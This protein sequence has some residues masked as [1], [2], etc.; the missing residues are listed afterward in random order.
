MY[1]LRRYYVGQVFRARRK[2][3]GAAILGS[4]E[5]Y[6]F[7]GGVLQL[8]YV[9]SLVVSYVIF[10]NLQIFASCV[11]AVLLLTST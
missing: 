11:S 2:A 4:V 10:A 1:S 5:L 6:L 7:F 8:W 9:T 3:A